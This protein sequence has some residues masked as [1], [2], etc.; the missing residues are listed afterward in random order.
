[1]HLP[2][3]QKANS[4]VILSLKTNPWRFRYPRTQP[5]INLMRGSSSKTETA[6]VQQLRDI[7]PK[8]R[9]PR[10]RVQ[11]AKSPGQWC[12]SWKGNMGLACHVGNLLGRVSKRFPT[13]Y[14]LAL[15]ISP[16]VVG[17]IWLLPPTCGALLQPYFGFLSDCFSRFGKREP[18]IIGCGIYLSV[19]LFIFAWTIEVSYSFAKL[20]RS[21]SCSE[22]GPIYPMA[23]F[24][25][26]FSILA[27]NV[28]AQVT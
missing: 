2:N 15:D 20:I 7:A 16:T 24:L 17:I 3:L 9:G 13:L 21:I 10:D 5:A 27:I 11:R 23:K 14:L 6:L 18:F 8:S 28:S 4:T 1:M 25:A 12:D 19:S 26:T 22:S